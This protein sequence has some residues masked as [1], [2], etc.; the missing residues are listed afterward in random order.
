MQADL[1]KAALADIL[2]DTDPTRKAA[3]LASLCSEV[4][5]QRGIDLVVVGG[6]A[7]ELL[8]EGAYTSGDLDFCLLNRNAVPLRERQELMGQL[9]GQGGPR[10]WQVAGQFVDLL[11]PL[12]S[13]ARTPL[14]KLA[15]PYGLVQ[16]IQPEE[17]LVERILVSVYPQKSVPARQCARK[18]AA[19]ALGGA[20]GL[21]WNEVERLARLPEYRIFPE[22]QKVIEE[23]AN[24]LKVK[25]PF[26]PHP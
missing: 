19:V 22:C 14:R 4:F 12:E 3:K 7:I 6:S 2:A 1:V 8:T 24:E 18:L 16:I 23:I 9:Q 26:H 13:L 17:L 20:L 25:T 5:R 10:S 11:G 21:D 15:G